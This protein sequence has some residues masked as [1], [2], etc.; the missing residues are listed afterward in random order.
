MIETSAI[1]IEKTTQSRI[2]E[3]DENNIPFG[4]LYSD[5][6]FLADYKDGQWQ[7]LR[8][9]P[10][11]NISLSPANSA[12]HYGI[13]IFEGL[14]AYRNKDGEV[15]VFRP[16][17]NA[18]R[19]N[20]SAER[21]CIP[22][23]PEGLFMEALNELL[24]I[25]ASWVPSAP[26]TALYIRPFVFG[27]DEYI[28]IRPS[29]N[30]RFMIITGPVGSYYTKPVRVKIETKFSRAF[31]GGTGF[32][33]AGGNYAASLYP[34]R[35][36]QKMGFDQLI[37]TD[38]KTHQYIEESGTMNVMFM[39]DDVLIT[40]PTSGTILKGITRD[41]VLTIA[42]E[43]GVKVEE[44]PVAVAE[45]VAA[46]KEGRLKE[47]FGVGTAAT[48]APIATIGYEDEVYDLPAA[49][50]SFFSRKILKELSG[51]RSGEIADKHGWIYKI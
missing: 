16:E 46:A 25:D 9:V 12:L 1:R 27:M 3:L 18:K 41:S 32:A 11:Q 17:A 22:A 24:K 37:W 47:A 45:V 13:T 30:F 29:E 4:R 26:G 50:D 28:G 10:Y 48:I 51:I 19:L 42:R 43:W 7:D 35:L 33:K 49:D 34:A 36:A 44:R 21:M 20:I 2:N 6:M 40:A 14:K 8:I 5:H 38:G 31:E 15:V 39:I 23:V